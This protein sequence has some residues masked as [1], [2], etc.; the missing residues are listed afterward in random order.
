[1]GM[2]NIS[3]VEY[4]EKLVKREEIWVNRELFSVSKIQ[5]NQ[6][7]NGGKKRGRP[8][9]YSTFLICFFLL[10]KY[11]FKLAYRQLEGFLRAIFG[12]LGIEVPNFRTIWY[13]HSK[14]DIKYEINE[15]LS[16]DSIIV[17]DST[18]IKITNRSE[19]MRDRRRVSNRKGWVKVHVAY[20]VKSGK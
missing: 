9:K 4:N 10:I 3:W 1:M 8:Y 5:E 20:D 6:E 15:E 16:E 19:W 12:I 14:M 7:D 2:K 11:K 18:G 17:L 13:R